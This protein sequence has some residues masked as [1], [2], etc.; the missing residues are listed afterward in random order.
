MAPWV[1]TLFIHVMPR[2]LMMKRPTYTELEEEL[3][4]KFAAAL[5]ACLSFVTCRLPDRLPSPRM[6]AIRG[7]ASHFPFFAYLMQYTISLPL[8][9]LANVF[10][11]RGR[12]ALE[13]YSVRIRRRSPR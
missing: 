7:V 8:S 10:Q 11:N 13:G 9:P 4:S 1:R 12:A 5:T 2:L 6:A 3:A